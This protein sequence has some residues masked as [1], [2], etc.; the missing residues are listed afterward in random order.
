MQGGVLTVRFRIYI[1]IRFADCSFLRVVGWPITKKMTIF[2]CMGSAYVF[3]YC[4]IYI[5]TEFY[6]DTMSFS[7]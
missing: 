2:I 4:Y 5:Y 6:G 7:M 1:Y 3:L